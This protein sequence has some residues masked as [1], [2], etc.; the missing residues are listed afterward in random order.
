[1]KSKPKQKKGTGAK[2]VLEEVK[3]L[4]VIDL[5]V[6]PYDVLFTVG[7]T[8]VEVVD[9]LQN[10]CNYNLDDQEKAFLGF[11]GKQGRTVRLKN[12]AL[13][14]WVKDYN[15]P[16]L[17]HEIFHVVELLMEK[18]NVPLNEQTSETYAYLIEYLWREVTKLTKSK[19]Q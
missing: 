12:N 17:G 8:E 10:K 7:T 18:I 9:Y 14:L 13:I 4:H 1:M 5:V 6:Y 2:R 15:I 3:V 19:K 16:T 11:E